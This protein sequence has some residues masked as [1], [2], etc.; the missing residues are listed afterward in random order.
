MNKALR[1][2]VAAVG[3]LLGCA[4]LSAQSDPSG[5]ALAGTVLSKPVAAADFSLVD[6][7]GTAF[8][9]SSA[10]GKVVVLSFIYT[11][12]AD[13]CPFVTMKLEEARNLL[14]PDAARAV[15]VAIT[16]DPERDTQPVVADY[17]R[18]AGLYDYWHFLT[19]SAA[20]VQ[21]VWTAYGVGV[22]RITD[23]DTA[24]TGS[25]MSG[26]D[27][28][29]TQGLSK[30]ELVTAQKIIKNFGGGYD[31]SHTAPFWIIDTKGQLR[32]VLNADALPADIVADLRA[33]M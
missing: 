15:F 27:A 14:G 10:K 11:H 28:D 20:E 8:Q 1:L 24:D 3:V 21:K 32:A 33:L 30:G 23:A 16:T 29:H 5:P 18:A 12:C 25:A 2:L 22:H 13:I 4:S 17:S 6:Q 26:M 19:G 9:L 7:T 31:V